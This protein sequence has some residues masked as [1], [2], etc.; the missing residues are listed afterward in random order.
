MRANEFLTES[1]RLNEV[2]MSP[3]KLATQAA[4][5]EATCGIEFEMVVTNCKYDSDLVFYPDFDKVPDVILSDDIDSVDQ[6]VEFFRPGNSTKT[7]S[8]FS[9]EMTT[10]VKKFNFRKNGF[11]IYKKEI[12]SFFPGL[13][14][15]EI[16]ELWK[17]GGASIFLP[18]TK[19]REIYKKCMREYTNLSIKDFMHDNKIKSMYD[20]YDVYNKEFR[21]LTTGDL[22]LKWPAYK[23]IRTMKDV[24]KEFKAII[25]RQVTVSDTYHGASRRKN[26]YII[27]PD[28]SIKTN[29]KSISTDFG[30]EFVSPPLPLAEMQTDLIKVVEWAK[31]TGCYTNE[32]TGLHIN[33]SIPKFKINKLDFVKLV[34]LLGDE[35]VLNQFSR[36]ANDY[37]RSAFK[38]INDRAISNRIHD[39]EDV[40]YAL[41]A[42]KL[43]LSKIGSFV[44]HG[45]FTDKYTSIHV[46]DKYIEFRSPGGDWLNQPIDKIVTTINQFV[47]ALDAACDPEKYRQEYLKKFYKILTPVKQASTVGTNDSTAIFVK[48]VSGILNKEGLIRFLKANEQ[49]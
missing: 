17:I 32:S 7:I 34:L 27:E 38:E 29:K 33:V 16:K 2:N 42:M 15:V 10:I 23:K 44:I 6:L 8:T 35:Y 11:E 39:R 31:N 4:S 41:D 14:A 24:G 5:I 18:N 12:K 45:L 40:Q 26:T 1:R 30:L 37:C 47:V 21:Y 48:Y 28:G 3:S 25:G 49:L 43:G 22:E 13:K 46:H 20:V 19:K 36:K 9:D